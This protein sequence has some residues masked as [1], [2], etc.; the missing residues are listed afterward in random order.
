VKAA[1]E[2]VKIVDHFV[3]GMNHKIEGSIYN[4]NTFSIKNIRLIVI[5]YSKKSGQYPVHYKLLKFEDVVPSGLSLRFSERDYKLNYGWTAK[6]RVLD[7]DIVQGAVGV[8]TIPV[9]E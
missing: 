5:Y 2:N 6:F 9:F 3:S 8:E 4:G 7:Y 1:D